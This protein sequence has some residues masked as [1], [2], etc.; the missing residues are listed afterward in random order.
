LKYAAYDYIA[1]SRAGQVVSI[2][3]LLKQYSYFGL[4][5]VW[6]GKVFIQRYLDGAWQTMLARTADPAAQ[7]AV[8]FVQPKVFQ[9]RLVTP[10]R[11]D[12]WDAHSAS[13]V[14]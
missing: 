5:R 2:N 1:S 9:Y 13:T 10:E 11:D 7:L 14:R 3:G 6:S 8:S 4:E 12:V